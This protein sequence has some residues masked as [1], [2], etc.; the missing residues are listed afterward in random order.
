MGVPRNIQSDRGK[1]FT[2]D[3]F[4]T[5]MR[6]LGTVCSNSSPYNPRSQGRLER[7]HA[8][9]RKQ[10]KITHEQGRLWCVE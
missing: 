5:T 2:S 1:E 7:I 8:E 6:R 10:L 9:V 4:T 3:L